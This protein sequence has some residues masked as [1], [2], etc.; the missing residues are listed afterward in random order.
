MADY[1]YVDLLQEHSLAA[2]IDTQ[3]C[4]GLDTEFVREKTFFSRLC[5]IQISIG[6]QIIC[7]DP[8]GDN[9]GHERVP[10]EFWE[11]LTGLTWVLHSGRQD[12][13]VLYQASNRM[14]QA[15]FDTQ[16]AAALLGFQPQIGYANLVSELFDVELAKTHTRADWSRRPLPAEFIDYAAEDVVYLLPARDM[17]EE[18][19]RAL[20]RLGWAEQDSAELLDE[21][22]YSIDPAV[23]IDRVK[24]ARN[25][26]GRARSAAVAL[27]AWR[28]QEALQRNRPRQ[29]IIRDAALL[30]IATSN[31]KQTSALKEIPG[32]SERTV[33]RAGEQFLEILA[34]AAEDENRYVPPPRPD[35]T[36]KR[37]L[38]ELQRVVARCASELD[39]AP[40]IIAPKKEL[41]Q[42][43]L[44]VTSSRV[45]SGWR[46]ELVGTKLL[47]L[48][49]D[50]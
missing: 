1:Q 8:I 40:E 24:G 32:L 19:L 38:K 50:R 37:K 43:V 11:A 33:D 42:A 23:A 47:E 34:R 7:A 21:S 41:S 14:P 2:S 17:L 13:E 30:E 29:W 9:T 20:G 18:R 45:F 26:R 28:E 6:P 31:A 16:V 48:L 44:G 10:D 25:L 36:Q 3:S 5:L 4:I 15:V 35:E 22:L 39:L 27:A 12:V 49:D 46:G